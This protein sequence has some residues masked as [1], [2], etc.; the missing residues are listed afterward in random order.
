MTFK[1]IV[2]E[3]PVPEEKIVGAARFT[4]RAD[5]ISYADIVCADAESSSEILKILLLKVEHIAFSHGL[6]KVIFGIPQWRSDLEDMLLAA[7]YCEQSGHIWP[8]DKSHEL[9]KPTMILEYH[10]SL[11]SNQSKV[12]QAP[13]SFDFSTSSSNAY[14]DGSLLN[15]LETVSEEAC[16]GEAK[17][18]MYYNEDGVLCIDFEV[19]EI[20]EAPTATAQKG[21]E[22]NME[23][24]I[25]NL[26]SALHKSFD[27][28]TL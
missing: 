5:K 22:E 27:N 12:V 1:W 15:K 6:D 14:L 8:E 19:D 11:Y 7:G 9:L 10:K 13:E 17:P 21:K 2:L 26:F 16:F 23:S 28:H 4:L 20:S 3:T 25:E 24:L 18:G